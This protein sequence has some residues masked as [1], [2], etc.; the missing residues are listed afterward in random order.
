[1]EG[2]TVSRS[3][4]GCECNVLLY[5]GQDRDVSVSAGCI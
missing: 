2:L 1:M 3:G 4:Q 5:L